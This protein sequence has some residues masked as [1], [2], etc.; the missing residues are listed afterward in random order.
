MFGLVFGLMDGVVYESVSHEG[1]VN[2]LASEF[3][4]VLGGGLVFGLAAGPAYGLTRGLAAPV[5]VTST[6]RVRDSLKAD[7]QNAIVQGL[8]F[9]LGFG[10]AL[11]LGLLDRLAD[12]LWGWF[13]DLFE[14]WSGPHEAL[15]GVQLM[16]ELSESA[17]GPG[18]EVGLGLLLGLVF[19]LVL[20]LPGTAWGQWLVLGRFWLPVRGRV[21]WRLMGFLDDAHRRGVL[22][23]VGA[24]YQFRHARLQD[25]LAAD[26]GAGRASR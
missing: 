19:G 7:R 17:Y 4:W 14:G 24:V 20:V 25:H 26:T 2:G 11:G 3:L 10:V 18:V 1:P 22:R 6:V 9:V 13:V 5:D 15:R 8:V 21:P 12:W 16:E 23:Q